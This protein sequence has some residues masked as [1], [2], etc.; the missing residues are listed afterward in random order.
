V[1]T[2]QSSGIEWLGRLLALEK[3]AGVVADEALRV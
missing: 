2:R 1:Q 3:A